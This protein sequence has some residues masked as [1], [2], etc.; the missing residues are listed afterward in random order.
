MGKAFD[1]ANGAGK[2]DNPQ[3]PLLSHYFALLFSEY[4]FLF[5]CYLFNTDIDHSLEHLYIIIKS[6]R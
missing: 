4:S 6:S 5:F 3:C 1:L 2:G